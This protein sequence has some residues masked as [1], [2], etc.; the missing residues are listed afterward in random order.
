[1]L[2]HIFLGRQF[3]QQKEEILKKEVRA[4]RLRGIQ[5]KLVVI[6]VGSNEASKLYVTLKKQAAERSGVIYEVLHL[7]EA[8]EAQL[9]QSIKVLNKDKSVHGIMVQLPLPG[10]LGESK[11]R[12]RILKSISPKKDVDGETSRGI[13]LPAT[14]KAILSVIE[15]AVRCMEEDK[16][17]MVVC[18]VGSTGMVGEPLIKKIQKDFKQVVSCDIKTKNLKSQTLKADLLISATGVPGLIKSDMVSP[19]AIVID[20]GSPKGDVDIDVREVAE[21]VTPV[22]GG[23]GPMTVISLVENTVLAASKSK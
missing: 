13:F 14:V 6:W 7:N 8:S 20:V 15:E 16:K 12:L 22:P 9:L 10:Q 19:G 11:A 5:P 17:N 1:M 23:V 4:L 21:F 18:V 2:A 3:A